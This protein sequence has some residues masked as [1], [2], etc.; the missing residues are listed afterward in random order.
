[1]MAGPQIISAVILTTTP[2]PV[3]T[4][5]GFLTGVAVAAL[6]GVAV[7]YGIASAIGSA[8]D[9]GGSGNTSAGQ[10]VEYVLVGLLILLAGKNWVGRRTAEPPAWLGRLMSAGPR[11]AAEIGTL[12]IL[13]MPSDL[14]VMLTVGV[15]L[16]QHDLSYADALPFV[17][18]TLLVAALPLLFLL[19]FHRRAEAAMP[20]VRD[21]AN[22]H[23]WLINIAVCLL[24]VVLILL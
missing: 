19:L 11:R 1:M 2:R 21:W 23:S 9:V 24:F 5:L 10:I 12:I 18:L 16:A 22:T 15:H 6:T 20:K 13:L 3:R 8:V 14:V 7:A 4:S 17:G